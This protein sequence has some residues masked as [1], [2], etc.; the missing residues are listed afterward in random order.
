MKN[1]LGSWRQAMSLGCDSYLLDALQSQRGM[2]RPLPS[3]RCLVFQLVQSDGPWWNAFNVKA[4]VE[5]PCERGTDDNTTV[6]PVRRVF[7]RPLLKSMCL[8]REMFLNYPYFPPGYPRQTSSL[9]ITSRLPQRTVSSQPQ[10][11][12]QLGLA[13]QTNDV[14]PTRKPSVLARL[15]SLFN[16]ILVLNTTRK[17]PDERLNY[18]PPYPLANSVLLGFTV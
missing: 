12:I 11:D 10:T 9:S 6:A 15:S 3:H 8:S 14:D 5:P 7:L 1:A 2:T 16:T 4:L 18:R 13:T 17:H